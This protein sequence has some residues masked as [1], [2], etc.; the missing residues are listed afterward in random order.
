MVSKE[1]EEIQNSL[2]QG[3]FEKVGGNSKRFGIRWFQ[4]S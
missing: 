4:D 3:D 1:L 2:E